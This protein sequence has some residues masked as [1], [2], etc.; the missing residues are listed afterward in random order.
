MTVE[1]DTLDAIRVSMDTRLDT[2]ARTIGLAECTIGHI[3]THRWTHS[4]V[5][6]TRK[7]L[8]RVK[9]SPMLDT[10]RTQL[11]ISVSHLDIMYTLLD[12]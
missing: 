4:H 9:A 1:L 7:R 11:D 12:T 2:M 3:G 8:N 10:S 6:Y 5:N